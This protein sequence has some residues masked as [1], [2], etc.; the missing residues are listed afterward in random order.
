V[1]A[2]L[3]LEVAGDVDRFAFSH[4]LIR[5][6]LYEQLTTASRVR[7]HHR[8]AQA[9]ERLSERE[10]VN[11]AELAHHYELAR[12]V[13]GPAPS[14]RYSIAAGKDA[15]GR[16][17]YEEAA[18]HFRRALQLFDDADEAGRCDVLLALGRVQWHAGDDGARDTFLAAADSAERRGAADQLA[19]AALGLGERY[20]EVT[21]LGARYRDLLENALTAVGSRD[22]PRRALL[23]A[24]LAVNLGFPNE[25]AR[26]HSL[27]ADAVS[28][29]RRIGDERLLAAVLLAR[30][31]TLL[32][33]RHIEQR[34][35]I[36][37]ELSSLGDTHHELTAERHHWR[38]YDL[39]SVGEVDAARGEH[40]SLVGLAKRL[41]QPLLRSL[42]EGSC[43]LWA[44]LAGDAERAERHAQ[45]SF[46]Q[47]QLAHTQDAVSSWASQLFALRRRQG[48]VGELGS[49]AERL[50]G[51][52]GDQLGWLSAL[53]V[54]RF[55]TGDPEAARIVY[56]RELQAGVEALPRGM[57]WL[58]RM[59]LL[60]ELSAMLGDVSGAKALYA[61]LLPYVTRNVVV[62]YCSFW[63][64]VEG[65]LAL[66]AKTTGN[67]TLAERHLES[68]SARTRAINAPWLTLDLQE[69]SN[70]LSG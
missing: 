24:R 30:H 2:R 6:V 44:E 50:A 56:E 23:L 63:G 36:G 20:F 53:G 52:G 28:M 47:A 31:V 1:A 33:I 59:A 42:A 51:S 64:P 70:R 67:A 39:L 57:F 16:F 14:R 26:A 22:S 62:T 8:V 68:A 11:P 61:E 12:H 55:E 35:A 27:A 49:I 3:V 18:Q 17:A 45:V 32:D 10:I 43:S 19:R 66:L 21:Y 65:Y 13:A 25:A 5:E 29:A 54:L 69:R 34:L 7:L 58:T 48:R 41:G 40:E 15:A 60:S 37:A 38:M 46:Q 4:A 9:L